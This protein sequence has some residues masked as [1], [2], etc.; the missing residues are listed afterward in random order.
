[1][2][3]TIEIV[4]KHLG[5]KAYLVLTKEKQGKLVDLWIPK[6]QIMETDC[7]AENDQ[8]YMI[9]SKWFAEKANL[10]EKEESK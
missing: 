3:A 1:M 5:T 6:S 7:L 10:I 2:N 4:L 8:G 9:V